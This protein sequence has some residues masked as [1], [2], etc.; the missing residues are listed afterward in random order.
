MAMLAKAKQTAGNKRRK[1]QARAGRAAGCCLDA[2]RSREPV[3]TSLENA[4]AKAGIARVM[5]GLSSRR[6]EQLY[7]TLRPNPSAAQAA[8]HRPL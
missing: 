8:K 6:T 7:Y 4:L 1:L 3:S 2:L 5:S